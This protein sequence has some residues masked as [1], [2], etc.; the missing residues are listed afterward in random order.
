MMRSSTSARARGLWLYL[1]PLWIALLAACGADQTTAPP[2]P[3]F[4]KTSLDFGSV[5][6]GTSA[7]RSFTLRNTGAGSLSGTIEASC[8][9]YEV[10][11]EPARTRSVRTS[12]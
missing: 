3:V 5:L 11:A 2:N 9:E 12:S 1:L 10:I 8:P 6:L 7:E 4:D